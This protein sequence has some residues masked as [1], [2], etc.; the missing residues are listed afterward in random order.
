M[1]GDSRAQL[2]LGGTSSL[3]G[4]GSWHWVPAAPLSLLS[5]GT[6][7][8]VARTTSFPFYFLNHNIYTQE[9]S[10]S[11]FFFFLLSLNI[12]NWVASSHLNTLFSILMQAKYLLYF[13]QYKHLLFTFCIM[14]VYLLQLINL[15]WQVIITP[16]L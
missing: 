3:A 4:S 8:L 10:F 14:V 16:N 12:W 5:L 7:L 1:P 2:S 6:L 9:C 11:K 15:H 13:M